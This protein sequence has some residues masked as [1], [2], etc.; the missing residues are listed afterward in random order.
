MSSDK[1]TKRELLRNVLRRTNKEERQKYDSIVER[2]NA[3]AERMQE[4]GLEIDVLSERDKLNKFPEK[5]FTYF[6]APDKTHD[7]IMGM[8]SGELHE[9]C[10]QIKRESSE[11]NAG[12][13]RYNEGFDVWFAKTTVI[14]NEKMKLIDES[15][16]LKK[17][18][19]SLEDKEKWLLLS[20]ALRSQPNL[21]KYV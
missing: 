16:T 6:H 17:E 15:V 1:E 18:F 10:E 3:I 12:C 21:L 19:D 11:Y 4:I 5:E 2:Q 13:K 7:E 9:W 8:S 20:I 14:S